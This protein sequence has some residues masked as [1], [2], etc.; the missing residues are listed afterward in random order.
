MAS[1]RYMN[2]DFEITSP[3]DLKPIVESFG[4]DVALLYN[5]KWNENFRAVF[6]INEFHSNANDTIDF[7]C[8]LVEGFTEKE[9]KIWDNCFSK[10]FDIGYEAGLTKESYGTEIRSEVIKRVAEI[11]ASIAITIYPPHELEKQQ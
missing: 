3:I 11:G 4:D 10:V 8:T 1:T 2:T 6:E 7:F 9:R 5:G